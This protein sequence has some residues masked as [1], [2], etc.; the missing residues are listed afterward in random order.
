MRLHPWYVLTV[1]T[2]LLIGCSGGPDSL[3]NSAARALIEKAWNGPDIGLLIGSVKFVADNP[4]NAEGRASLTELPLYKRFEELGVIA[5]AN[6]RD[7]TRNF[8][9][10]NNFYALSQK[11]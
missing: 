7:L 5:I 2:V 3:G 4:D 10:W 11:L 6:R 8:G 1:G 9:G